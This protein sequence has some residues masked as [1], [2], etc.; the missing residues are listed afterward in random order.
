MAEDFVVRVSFDDMEPASPSLQNCIKF[1]NSGRYFSALCDFGAVSICQL[2]GTSEINFGNKIRVIEGNSSFV[3]DL[4][5]IRRSKLCR[6]TWHWASSPSRESNSSQGC[7]SGT[8]FSQLR[9]CY[10]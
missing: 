3:S 7:C 2:T 4:N 10:R 6:V 8:V 1:S 5:A 9:L